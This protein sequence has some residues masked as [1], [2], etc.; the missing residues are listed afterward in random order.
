MAN[1]KAAD[2]QAAKTQV[3]TG[4]VRFSYVHVFEPSAMEGQTDKKYSV[5]LIIPKTDTVTRDKVLAAIEV[6]KEIGKT[7]KFGG[8]IPTVNFKLPL[9]D[10]DVDRP[11]HP[12]YAGCW[13]LNASSKTK[14]GI[15]DINRVPIVDTTE[16]Y[17]GAYGRASVNFYSFNSNGSKG[18]ACGLNHIQKL[19]DGEPLGGRGTAEDAFA[20]EDDMLG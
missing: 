18:I 3:V 2:E 9:R 14:P 17:S 7:K 8:K 4:K 16:V 1:T 13:F 6:A 12:E 11:E 5:S 20:D 19:E 10:G 15:V